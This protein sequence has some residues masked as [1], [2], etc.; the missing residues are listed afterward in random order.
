MFGEVCFFGYVDLEAAYLVNLK[1]WWLYDLVVKENMFNVLSNRLYNGL[2]IFQRNGNIFYLPGQTTG[3]YTIR[4]SAD[5]LTPWRRLQAVA[6]V[7]IIS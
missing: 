5:W 3:G 6:M 7:C 4:Q 1:S 2:D